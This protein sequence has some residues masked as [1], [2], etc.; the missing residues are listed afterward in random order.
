MMQSTKNCDFNDISHFWCFNCSRLRTIFVKRQMCTRNIVIFIAIFYENTFQMVLIEYD[1]MIRTIMT[2]CSNY[3]FTISILPGWSECC[4][5]L[6]DPGDIDPFDEFTSID[7]FIISD[8][9]S[10]SRIPW[11]GFDDLL[12]SPCGRWILCDIEMNNFP[13]IMRQHHEYEQYFECDRWDSE[14][15][16]WG[17]VFGVVI[18][19]GTPSLGRRLSAFDHVSSHRCPRD[20]NSKL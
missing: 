13:A 9:I 6:S 19:E 15:V 18:E 16:Y 10:G 20:F 5:Y 12:P 4:F 11:V 8:K 1:Y 17:D 2:N 14:K 7:W 3:S